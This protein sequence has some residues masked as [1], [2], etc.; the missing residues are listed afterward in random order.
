M[1]HYLTLPQNILILIPTIL[2][3]FI[4]AIYRRYFLCV[5]YASSSS[6]IA[7]QKKSNTKISELVDGGRYFFYDFLK[8]IGMLAVLIIH[9]TYIYKDDL[10]FYNTDNVYYYVNNLVNNLTRFTIPFFLLISG[11]LLKPFIMQKKEIVDFYRKKLLRLIPPYILCVIAIHWD[12]PIAEIWSLGITGQADVPF[13]FMLVLFQCY[14]LYPLL[15]YLRKY[16]SVTMYL[17]LIISVV[18]AIFPTFWSAHDVPLCLKY[19]FFFAYGAYSR[20]YFLN[21]K[22]ERNKDFWLWV[23][24]IVYY[25][26]YC[27]IFSNYYYNTRF[28]WGLATFHMVF[29]FRDSILKW[30]IFT[31]FFNFIG[32]FSLWI[33]LIHYQI[34]LG[35]KSYF[36]QFAMNFYIEQLCNFFATFI[37]TIIASFLLDLIYRK[38]TEPFLKT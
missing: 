16:V 7:V 1:L 22:K 25:V 18:S 33:F 29:Y 23:I 12:R 27:L 6:Q 38:I 4:P 8:G 37:V 14:F 28:F 36:E 31:K 21:Y 15:V 13:Y 24:C 32:R 17:L 26:V 9:V 20:E 10:T 5:T 30:K 3:L 35:F 2:V 34:M 19:I 11:V